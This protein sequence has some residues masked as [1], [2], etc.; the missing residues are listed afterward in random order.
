MGG[1]REVNCS[2]LEAIR[3][4]EQITGRDV[5]YTY[6]EKNR[7]GDHIW[8]ISSLT[9][10]QKDYPD[11]HIKNRLNEILREIYELNRDHW[12]REGGTWT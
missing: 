2:L 11:W 3:A 5:S 6:E 1:G 12:L 7:R 4:C 9:A 10:F 8:W